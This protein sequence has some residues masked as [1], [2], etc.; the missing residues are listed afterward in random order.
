[1][2]N[3]EQLIQTINQTL[4]LSLDPAKTPRNV[5]LKDLGIDSLDFFSILTEL[6]KITGKNVSDDDVG[7]LNTVNAIV[8]FFNS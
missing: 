6:E 1:M 8:D 7:K 5:E 4:N 2:P 3:A